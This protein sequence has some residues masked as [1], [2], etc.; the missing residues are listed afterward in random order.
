[1]AERIGVST[2]EWKIADADKVLFTE[3]LN[4]CIGLLVYDHERQA[5]LLGHWPSLMFRRDFH[6]RTIDNFTSRSRLENLKGYLRGSSPWKGSIVDVRADEERECA[7]GFLKRVGLDRD[8]IDILWNTHAHHVARMEI[9]TTTGDFQSKIQMLE[10]RSVIFDYGRT[11]YDPTTDQLFP[12][13]KRVLGA[14]KDR[15]LKLGLV[16]IAERTIG[17]RY[18]DLVRFGI[19]DYFDEVE[20]LER[21]GR[22]KDFKGIFDRLGVE[23]QRSIIVGDNLKREIRAGNLIGAYTVWTRERLSGTYIPLE[24]LQTPRAIIDR[25]GELI[26]LVDQFI[27]NGRTSYEGLLL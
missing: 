22:D 16:S 19:L 4:V 26:P 5:A 21:R 25:L 3:G 6:Q 17:Q 2:D 23:A 12:D 20:V 15:G 10:S 13:T 14:L 9:N 1:M 7:V 8:H 18:G 11:I 27:E 24:S